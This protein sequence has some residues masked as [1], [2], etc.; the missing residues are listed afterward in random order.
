[1]KTKHI[2]YPLTLMLMLALPLV[3]YYTST[4]DVNACV[5]DYVD[6]MEDSD[7]S[8]YLYSIN[9]YR[10]IEPKNSEMAESLEP[11]RIWV[12]DGCIMASNNL[13]ID[14][15]NTFYC[16]VTYMIKKLPIPEVLKEPLSIYKW[17]DINK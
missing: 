9:W 11:Y 14:M 10:H 5:L 17:G 15:T 13:Y 7:Y 8:W 4:P 16:T 1:M 6:N 3:K 12:A 2:L